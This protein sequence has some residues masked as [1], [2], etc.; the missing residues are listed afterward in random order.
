VLERGRREK[1]E[2]GKRVDHDMGEDN[3]KQNEIQI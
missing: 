2:K 3:R 1:G